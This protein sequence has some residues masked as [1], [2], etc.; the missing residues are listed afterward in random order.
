MTIDNLSASIAEL[1]PDSR[2]RN[3]I[4]ETVLD[5]INEV[6]ACGA[7]KWGVTFRDGTIRLFGWQFGCIHNRKREDQDRAGQGQA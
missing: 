4:L 6:H 3:A 1:I 5:A 7:E 2:R